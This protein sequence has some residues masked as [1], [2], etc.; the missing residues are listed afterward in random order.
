V[1]LG[2]SPPHTDWP[3]HAAGSFTTPVGVID[4]VGQPL[5]LSGGGGEGGITELTGD[6]TAGPGSGSQAATLATVNPNVGTF[7]YPSSISANGKGLITAI[8]AG[9]AP[10][11]VTSV[12]LTMPTGVFD[13][14]GSPVT[15]SGT[16]A[17]TFDNQAQNTFFAGPGSGGTGQPAFRA[18]VTNDLLGKV[19]VFSFSDD[20]FHGDTVNPTV[21]DDDTSPYFVGAHWLNVAT[22]IEFVCVD[23][24]TGAAVWPVTTE[25]IAILRDEK[26]TGTAGGTSSNTTWNARNINTEL[27]DPSFIVSISS[28]QFTP[29]IGTYEILVLAPFTGGTAASSLGRCRLYNVTAGA[30]VEEGVSTFAL[31]NAAA[32]G[33][34][35]CTFAANGTDAYRIDS[36]TSVGRTTNGLGVAVSDGSAEVYTQVTLR[37]II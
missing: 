9:S 30:V 28:N 11:T 21:N 23:N 7:A 33:V 4:D 14:S 3:D 25:V 5:R 18:L 36:Y 19:D 37:K 15:G 35:N 20:T 34:L 2:F 12:G 17:V 24:T 8:T 13:I 27:Y 10:G 26:A 32:I 16:L 29:I 22:G 1:P 31:T 6:V